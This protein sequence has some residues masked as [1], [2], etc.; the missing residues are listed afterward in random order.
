MLREFGRHKLRTVLTMLGVMI[1]IF[2]VTSVSSFSEGITYFV[3]DQ[4]AITSGLVTVVEKGVFGFMIQQSEIDEDLVEEVESISGVENVAAILFETVDG[5]SITGTPPGTENIIR[6]VTIEVGEGR[7][8]EEG[9]KEL[10]IGTGYAEKN[11]YS[12]GDVIKLDEKEYEIVGI[13]EETGDSGMDNSVNMP[14]KDLQEL[15]DN[16]GKIS[17]MMIQPSTPADA[18]FIEQA[19]NDDF[20]DIQAASDKSIMN[21]VSEMTSQL[22]LMTFALGS[23]AALISGIVIMNVMIISVRERRRDIGTM[24]AIGATNKQVLL[25]ILLE[26]VTISVGGAIVGIILS[27]GG[28]SYINMIL[29]QPL[30]LVTPRLVIQGILFAAFIGIVSG[31]LPARQAAKLS[32]IEA[33]RYE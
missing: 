11:D 16:E 18:D 9:Q 30:A 1:G 27:F 7:D 22:N 29:M 6:G 10:I 4:I 23:I 2:L 21:S 14:L 32:P 15:T 25:A 5:V 13:L 31:I 20:D 24:K 26:A 8:Y 12:V 19:I 17:I 28:T 33:L 3:N